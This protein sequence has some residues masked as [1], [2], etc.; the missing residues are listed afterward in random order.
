[1]KLLRYGPA[2]AER[3]GLIDRDGRLRDLSKHA[4]QFCARGVSLEAIDALRALDV[5]SLPVVEQD[6]RIGACLSLVPTFHCIGLNYAKHAAETGASTPTEPVLFN[7]AATALC[8]PFD[9]IIR[10]LDSVS[11]DYEVELGVIIGADTHYVSEGEALDRVAGYC[12]VND[13]SERDY[14][15]HRQGQWV[16]GKSA[17]SFGPVGPWL[18]TADEISDPQALGLWLEVNGEERQKSSTADMI[19]SVAEIISYMSKFMRLVPGDI[20]ATGTPQGVA[21]GMTPPGWLVPGDVV[22]LGIDGL[23]VQEHVVVEQPNIS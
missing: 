17:P 9:E 3:P 14:Q 10:P 13:V 20:I 5:T 16:K 12:V 11:L 21:M 22:R 18:V 15:K 4:A 8:G 19:F 23:G 6:T 1:M 7:K 2:G